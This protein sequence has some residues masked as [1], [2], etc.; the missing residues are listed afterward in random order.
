MDTKTANIITIVVGFVFVLLGIN[1][2]LNAS[3]WWYYITFFAGIL[4]VCLGVYGY[5]TGR[6]F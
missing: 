4:I 6:R 3:S 2:I 5:K 1:N